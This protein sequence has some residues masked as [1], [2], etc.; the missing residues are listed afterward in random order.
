MVG[1]DTNVI[2]RYITQDDPDQSKMATT[3]IEKNCTVENPGYINEIVLCEIVWVLK[4][5]YQYD[6]KV[7]I[8]VLH[9]L[10]MTSELL[11]ENADN[12]RKATEA[13]ISGNADFSDYLIAISNH[14]KGCT[15]TVSFDK[16]F[17]STDFVRAI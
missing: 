16:N 13:Y 3:F 4:R 1:L 11:V 8:D 6:K 17:S 2:V 7:I 15:Y 14:Q 12:V 9:K 10:Q 5:A